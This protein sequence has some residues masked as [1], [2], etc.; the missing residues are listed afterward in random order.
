[1]VPMRAARW[2]AFFSS[3]RAAEGGGRAG[4]YFPR[5]NDPLRQWRHLAGDRIALVDRARDGA[6]LTYA[7]FDRAADKWAALLEPQG[8][9]QRSS[10]GHRRKSR[11]SRRSLLRMHEN[12]SGA[13]SVQLA[14]RTAGAASDSRIMRIRR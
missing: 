10:S 5:Y 7:E 12:W 1:M 6:R 3:I 14:A 11:G 9:P 4:R 13:R 2:S 8:W